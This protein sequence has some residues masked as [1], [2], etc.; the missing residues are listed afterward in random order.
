MNLKNSDFL[1]LKYPHTL[2][3]NVILNEGYTSILTSKVANTQEKIEYFI[4]YNL[5]DE[6]N[7]Y[8]CYIKT[9]KQSN[10]FGENKELLLIK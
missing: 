3:Q 7:A 2:Y 6:V 5:N 4:A 1:D 8:T 10:K 9:I